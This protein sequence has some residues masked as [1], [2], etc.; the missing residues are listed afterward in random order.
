M[1]MHVTRL[2]PATI[3]KQMSPIP[4]VTL[5][6]WAAVT[7]VTA[8]GGWGDAHLAVGEGPA[9]PSDGHSCYLGFAAGC[10]QSGYMYICAFRFEPP[11]RPW[12]VKLLVEHGA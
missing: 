3:P 7:I 6:R 1:Y 2:H 5:V 11:P 4:F 8:G 12:I 9:D 10:M